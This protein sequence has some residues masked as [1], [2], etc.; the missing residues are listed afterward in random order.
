MLNSLQNVRYSF[1][2]TTVVVHKTTPTNSSKNLFLYFSQFSPPFLYTSATFYLTIF[3]YKSQQST[4][5]I[6]SLPQPFS[7][8][9]LGQEVRELG[10]FVRPDTV[11]ISPFFL[12][13]WTVISGLTTTYCL[14]PRLRKLV[15][16]K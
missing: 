1:I 7:Q 11:L 3:A 13:I 4:I 8:F 9:R 5:K 16:C 10:S 12:K 14:S 2:F 6:F 15:Y